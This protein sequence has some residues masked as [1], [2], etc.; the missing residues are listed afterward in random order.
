MDQGTLHEQWMTLHM[1]GRMAAYQRDF[2]EHAKNYFL[3][4]IKVRDPPRT[5]LSKEN[6]ITLPKPI[7][8][9][10]HQDI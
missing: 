3:K 1:I 7:S 2:V 8:I 4:L 10:T 6:P 5:T 9:K